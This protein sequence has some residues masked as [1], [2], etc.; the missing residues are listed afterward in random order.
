ME[1]QGKPIKSESNLRTREEAIRYCGRL[2]VE[3]WGHVNEAY[4]DAMV[5]SDGRLILFIWETLL[6]F[7]MEPDA[8]KKEELL[9]ELAIVQVPRGVNQKARRSKSRDRIIQ[10]L[11]LLTLGDEHLE[12]IQKTEIFCA[13]VDNKP[14]EISLDAQSVEEV[15]W[16]N[17]IN[18]E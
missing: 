11:D 4:V 5:Q 1:F 18:V 8:A 10:V 2:L 6:Q 16:T 15:I 9:R 13:D 7:H 17:K 12:I 3:A 14:K